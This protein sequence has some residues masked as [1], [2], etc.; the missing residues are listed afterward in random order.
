M[1]LA[2]KLPAIFRSFLD[3][4]RGRNHPRAD[5]PIPRYVIPDGLQGWFRIAE[6]DDVEQYAGELFRRCFRNPPPDAPRHF[7]ALVDADGEERTI[8]YIHYAK[9]EDTYLAGGMCIDERVFRRL[10]ADR[11]EQ[12]KRAGGI[13]EQM[14]RHTFAT[15]S[16]ANAIF[17]YV[18]DKRAERVDLRAGFQHTGMK[19]L[20]V[21]WP[22]PL[23]IDEQRAIV[24]RVARL[25]PF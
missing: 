13:A 19:H 20:I 23:P 4:F 16:Y 7:V 15:L 1:T 3:A 18:G 8:G 25:G 2:R 14:L 5:S 6:V 11:R 10:P 22:R 9:F 12:L 24:A 17:G 21:F